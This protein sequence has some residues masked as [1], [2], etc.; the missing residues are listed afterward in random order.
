MAVATKRQ[1]TAGDILSAYSDDERAVHTYLRSDPVAFCQHVLNVRP[2]RKQIEVLTSPLERQKSLIPWGRQFG[3]TTVMSWYLTWKVFAEPDYHAF[4]FAPS[5]EQSRLLWERVVHFYETAPYLVRY[6]SHDVKGHRLMVGGP[7]WNSS[8]EYIKTGLTAEKARGRTVQK[9][10]IVFDE[11]ASFLYP[12]EI[13]GVLE[14]LI[15]SQGGGEVFMSSPGEV[16][17]F[18]HQLYEDLKEQERLALEREETPRHRVYEATWSDTDHLSADFVAEQER[19]LTKQGRRWF[20]DREYLGA[21]TKTEGAFF[22]ADDVRA[23]Q[24]RTPLASGDKGSTWIY[25]L[26]PGLDRSPAVVLIARWSATL[27]RLEVVECLSLV[28]DGNHYIQDG[29]HERLSGYPDLLD[30][31]LDLRRERPIYRLYYDPGIEQTL[32]EILGNRFSVN[33]VPVRVGGYAAKLTALQDLQRSLASRRIVWEPPR[34]TAQLLGF[35]APVNPT[36][37]RFDFP[38]RDADIVVAL[39][40]LNRYLADH[41]EEPFVM[42]AVGGRREW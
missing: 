29:G 20:F 7:T 31:L 30:L 22:N 4:C 35:S 10:V 17:G 40:Q 34:I 11:L 3:K 1:P 19:I 21:W 26:D 2:H 36:T 37:G 8:V 9:G 38:D 24:S 13:T 23:C 14:P 41:V 27:R 28:R 5:G 15:A 33:V 42:E 39:C 12:A 18:S 16:G 6:C 25:S 32:S